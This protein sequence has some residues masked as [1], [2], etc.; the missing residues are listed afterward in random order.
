MSEVASALPVGPAPAS[1]SPWRAGLRGA[2]ANLLPGLVLQVF[3]LT[4]VLAYYYHGPTR[5]LLSRLAAYRSETGFAFSFISTSLFGAVLPLIYLWSS[6]LTRSR[7][8]WKQGAVL[9]VFWALKGVEVDALYRAMAWIFGTGVDVRTIVLKGFVDQFI[10]CP[11][12]AVPGTVLA[13]E[14]IESHFSARTVLADLRAGH[15]YRRRGL[16][17]LCSSYGVWLPAVGVIYALP[18]PLQLPLQ[19]LELCFYTLLVA[20]VTKRKH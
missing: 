10:Y 6:P 7:Y 8:D 5:E 13:Y 4:L 15:W 18:T 16:A 9:I 1:E 17:V 3:A 14:W 11:L 12:V 19:N 2:R 20:H